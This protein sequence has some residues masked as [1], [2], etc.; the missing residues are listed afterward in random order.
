MSAPG[1]PTNHRKA[2]IVGLV[3]A[4]LLAALALRLLPVLRPLLRLRLP[5]DS[6]RCFP[7]G[8]MVPGRWGGNRCP[9]F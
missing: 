4:A 1:A 3:L 5:W 8:V 2:W 6:R 9:W 7:A